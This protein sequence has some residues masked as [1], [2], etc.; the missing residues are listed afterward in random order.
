MRNILLT[1]KNKTR[2]DC[3]ASTPFTVHFVSFLFL[4]TVSICG[5][6][7]LAQTENQEILLDGISTVISFNSAD[8]SSAILLL[9]SDVELVARILL[10]KQYGSEWNE[11]PADD[12]AK[13]KARRLASVVKIL[14]H[15]ATLVGEKIDVGKRDQMFNRFTRRA[16]GNASVQQ[17]LSQCGA[18]SDDLKFWFANF[19]MCMVQLQYLSDQI[20]MPTQAELKKMFK[21]GGHPLEG[22]SWQNAKHAYEKIVRSKKLQRAVAQWLEEFAQQGKISFVQ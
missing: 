20:Q 14:A 12:A 11:H 4:L 10:V 19:Y 15:V 3:D 8:D 16:G 7:V 18:T 2:C 22:A 6:T 9:A 5:S 17:L 21:Q 13:F 1:L